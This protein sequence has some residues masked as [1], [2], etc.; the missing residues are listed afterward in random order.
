M[1]T[2][3]SLRRC[4]LDW[5]RIFAVLGVFFFHCV[6]FFRIS[7]FMVKNPQGYLLAE[8]ISNFM[9]LWIMPVIFSVSSAASVIALE[10]KSAFVFVRDRFMRL[11]VPF[12]FGVFVLIPPQVYLERLSKGDFYGG[13]IDFVPRYFEGWYGSGGNFAWMGLHLWYLLVLFI[14]SVLFL[15]LMLAFLKGPLRGITS[16][17][18]RCVSFPLLVFV[19]GA[20]LGWLN[21]GLNPLLISNQRGFGGWPVSY[22][23][24]LFLFTFL[25][26]ADRR[27]TEAIRKYWIVALVLAAASTVYLVRVW[28]GAYPHYGSR[29]Y[30]IMQWCCGFASWCYIIG[31]HGLF[32]RRFGSGG[33]MHRRLNEAVL[34]FYALHQ[35][36]IVI[37]GF[38]AVNFTI[39]PLAKFAIIAALSFVVVI[40]IYEWGVRRWGVMRLLFGMKGA[41]RG[42]A[43]ATLTAESRV[44]K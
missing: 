6:L 12:I 24:L 39:H 14:F 27:G 18:G 16:A 11:C 23:M 38:Y 37:A 41:P 15:P 5:L 9:M 2:K 32:L 7:G 1:H 44:Q 17:F 20:L 4:D 34:P 33:D 22:Y 13:F 43:A 10:R 42:I 8:V 21:A 29:P 26:H 35:T 25:L 30:A 19:P 3:E 31:L 28:S 40:A 36:V